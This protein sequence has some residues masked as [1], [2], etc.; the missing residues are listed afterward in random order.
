MKHVRPCLAGTRNAISLRNSVNRCKQMAVCLCLAGGGLCAVAPAFAQLSPVAMRI[1]GKEIPLAEV[2]YAYHNNN[3]KQ[4]GQLWKE[5][6]SGFV[7]RKLAVCAAEVAGLDTT[8]VFIDAAEAYKQQL[9]ERELL[10]ELLDGGKDSL[11]LVGGQRTGRSAE[12]VRVKHIFKR[13]P[14]NI[15]GPVLREAEA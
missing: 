1:G 9:F 4:Q 5:F 14:Q 7:N 12:A 13:L 6:L 10:R 2:E 8:D 15:P 11:A 3:R